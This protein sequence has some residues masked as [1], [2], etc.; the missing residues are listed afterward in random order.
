MSQRTAHSAAR[1]D[2]GTTD[3]RQTYDR[4]TT[5]VRQRYTHTWL[6]SDRR[7]SGENALCIARLLPRKPG[8]THLPAY[9]SAVFQRS[10]PMRLAMSPFPS[11]WSIQSLTSSVD[12]P[13]QRAIPPPPGWPAKGE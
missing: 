2:R 6:P 1:Y 11:I 3:V 8:E 5:D 10:G 13:A 9:A 4:R 7:N 12:A